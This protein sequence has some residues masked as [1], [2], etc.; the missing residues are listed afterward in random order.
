[1]KVLPVTLARHPDLALKC[2]TF[3]GM[4]IKQSGTSEF[5][6]GCLRRHK[7]GSFIAAIRMLIRKRFV[8]HFTLYLITLTMEEIIPFHKVMSTI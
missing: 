2:F 8:M 5:L 1:M 6:N 7:T 4:T 3:S